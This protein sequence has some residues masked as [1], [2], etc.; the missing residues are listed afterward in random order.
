MAVTAAVNAVDWDGWQGR[1]RWRGTWPG[2]ED[3]TDSVL[4]DISTLA[5]APKSVKVQ[6]IQGHI[7][8]DLTATLEFQADTD[9]MIQQWSGQTDA[10]HPIVEDY[11]LGPNKGIAPN[12]GAAGFV[13]DISLTTSGGASGDEI[14]IT[15]DF[16]KK[17]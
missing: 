5:P 9:Q 12:P 7:N 1:L 15:L 3:L 17:S 14:N 11:T 10:S 13:G 16:C 8:G 2:S 4:V 6:R